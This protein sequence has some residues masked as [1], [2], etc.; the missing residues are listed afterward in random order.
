MNPEL[1]IELHSIVHA[2]LGLYAH[3]VYML[4]STIVLDTYCSVLA[5]WFFE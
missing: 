1:S 2:L 4:Y 3:A 5:S